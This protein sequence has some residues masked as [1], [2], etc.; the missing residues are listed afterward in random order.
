MRA[1][2]KLAVQF[3]VATLV[4]TGIAFLAG[5]IGEWAIGKSDA[6][7]PQMIAPAYI[8][9]LLIFFIAVLLL[10]MTVAV[11]IGAV[12]ERLSGGR[13]WSAEPGASPNG[14]PSVP[15]GN[16]GASG[17]PPSVS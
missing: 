2:Y 16:S 7:R 17:T 4:T 6:S 13:R 10:I 14:G 8:P 5:P 11:L 3:G 12:V 15:L 9:A 1:S